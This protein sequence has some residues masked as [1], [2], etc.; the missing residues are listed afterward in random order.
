MVFW[1]SGHGKYVAVV[2]S[3]MWSE[4]DSAFANAILDSPSHPLY[5]T[6][7]K[8]VSEGEVYLI[9]IIGENDAT[10]PP[11]LVDLE[12]WYANHPNPSVPVL[13]DTTNSDFT[14]LYVQ[15]AWPTIVLFDQNMEYVA[16][17]TLDNPN[18][19]LDFINEL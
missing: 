9:T 5:G 7:S 10:V 6:F 3:A 13:A 16:G 8:K 19:A 12:A 2:L 17:P 14:N 15:V 1:K 18:A 4:A 11:S